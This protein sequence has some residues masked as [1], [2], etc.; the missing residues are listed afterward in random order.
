MQGL[1]TT[2]DLPASED[3]ESLA[4]H[5]EHTGR[6]ISPILAAAT[7]SADVNAFRAAVNC[8]G[9]R[10]A[11]LSKDLLRFN[12]FVNLCLGGIRFGINDI[13]AGGPDPGDDEVAPF[14]ES[15]PSQRR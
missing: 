6:S 11:G 12:N 15:V 4:V 8:V 5:D 9:S 13:N 10:V 14:Q 7:Q 2:I 1:G 3:V